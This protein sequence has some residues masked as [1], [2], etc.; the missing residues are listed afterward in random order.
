M[1]KA[2]FFDTYK[3]DLNQRQL[4]AI[5]K[6]FDAGYKGFEG[7]MT[8]K[9]YISITRASKATSTRDLQHLSEIGALHSFGK[10]RNVHYFLNCN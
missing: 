6:M 2:V 1:Q 7:G 3:D 5:N 10:G 9:K 8:T 4:K